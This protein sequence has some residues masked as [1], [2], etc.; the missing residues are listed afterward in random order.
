[1]HTPEQPSSDESRFDAFNDARDIESPNQRLLREVFEETTVANRITLDSFD[2]HIP[3]NRADIALVTYF[4]EAEAVE[5]LVAASKRQNMI[6]ELGLEFQYLEDGHPDRVFQYTYRDG[7]VD[8]IRLL[9]RSDGVKVP[10]FTALGSYEDNHAVERIRVLS[11]TQAQNFA[12]RLED[13]LDEHTLNVRLEN[14]IGLDKAM[15]DLARLSFEDKRSML[16][17]YDEI[18]ELEVIKPDTDALAQVRKKLVKTMLPGNKLMSLMRDNKLTNAQATYEAS[19]SGLIERCGL[20]AKST[21]EFMQSERLQRLQLL[22][23]QL[24]FRRR[25][26]KLG[27]VAL[28]SLATLMGTGTGIASGAMMASETHNDTVT[29]AAIGALVGGGSGLWIAI[30]KGLNLRKRSR[31]ISGFSTNHFDTGGSLGRQLCAE[32]RLATGY[33][34]LL[35]H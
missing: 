13:Q 4:P 1:M 14:E 29:G 8:Q 9:T 27:F 17:A 31:Y 6:R 33:I 7:E 18:Q 12:R 22:N 32:Q 3:D 2:P 34:S 23:E 5:P 28:S 21:K 25:A 10:V 20:D 35:N 19:L 15:L 11:Y 16:A 24:R 30:E 26:T